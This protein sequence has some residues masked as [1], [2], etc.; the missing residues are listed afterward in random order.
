LTDLVEIMVSLADPT[1][2][3][4][5]F[6]FAVED[7]RLDVTQAG[8][9]VRDVPAG[10]PPAGARVADVVAVGALAVTI[11]RS[12]ELLRAL[13]SVVDGWLAGR[14]AAKVEVVIAGDSISLTG[15]ASTERRQLVAAFI[16]R[17][18]GDLDGGEPTA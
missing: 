16:Q 17:H 9:N 8:G 7:F 13:L 18:A 14:R 10:A 15:P 6:E 1:E 12:P 4:E 3:P 2:R 5:Q 11:A